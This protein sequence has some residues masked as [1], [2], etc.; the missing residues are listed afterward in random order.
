M[1]KSQAT[2]NLTL[3]IVL[4]LSWKARKENGTKFLKIDRSRDRSKPRSKDTRLE[5]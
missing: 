1:S 4:A 3:P 2:I 5:G